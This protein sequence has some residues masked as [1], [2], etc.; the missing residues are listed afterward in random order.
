MLTL[1]LTKL[2]MAEVRSRCRCRCKARISFLAKLCLASLLLASLLRNL[3][4]PAS[5]EHPHITCRSTGTILRHALHTLA[6]PKRCTSCTLSTR[7]IPARSDTSSSITPH[8]IAAISYWPSFE[9]LHLAVTSKAPSPRSRPASTQ[10]ATRPSHSLR[11][12]SDLI[13]ACPGPKPGVWRI[14]GDVRAPVTREELRV[15]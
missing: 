12:H 13:C 1:I 3:L 15:S 6:N 11:D 4:S 7:Q 10:T 5:T 14:T 9:Q 8:G 2:N